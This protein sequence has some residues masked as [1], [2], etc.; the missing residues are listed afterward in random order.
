M[1]EPGIQFGFNGIAE[2]DAA[3]GLDSRNAAHRPKTDAAAGE[4]GT[5]RSVQNRTFGAGSGHRTAPSRL[6]PARQIL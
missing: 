4:K 5:G 1:P 6:D 2:W 3:L